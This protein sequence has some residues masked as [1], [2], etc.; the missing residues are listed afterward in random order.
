MSNRNRIGPVAVYLFLFFC[1]A[2]CA[3]AETYSLSGTVRD[4]ATHVVPSATVT[5]KK[6]AT[7]K[8]YTATTGTDGSY[9]IPDLAA[10]DYEVSAVAGEL[11]APPI[12]VTLAAAQT[13]DLTVSPSPRQKR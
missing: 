5:A 12:K 6:L 11:H 10:G 4:P 3:V 13:T 1:L 9:T 8:I 2:I 7:G